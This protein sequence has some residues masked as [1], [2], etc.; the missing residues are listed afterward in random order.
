MRWRALKSKWVRRGSALFFAFSLLG[1]HFYLKGRGPENIRIDQITPRYNFAEVQVSG[2]LDSDARKMRAG[3]TLFTVNDGSGT[4]AVF[5]DEPFPEPLPK[6]GSKVTAVG[7][8]SVGVGNQVRLRCTQL[9][10]D[11]FA[12]ESEAEEGT[13][14]AVNA[15]LQGQQQTVKGTVQF[16][17]S[18]PA[19]S[20]APHKIIL[21]DDSA[22]LAVIHWLENPPDI[23]VGDVVEASGVV[24]VYRGKVELKVLK[25]GAIQKI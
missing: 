9:T 10:V 6:T 13:L 18:P 20:K 11:E 23:K 25:E 4:L 22:S 16:I 8:L 2:K 21:R 15:G 24:N 5:H 1:L 3:S 7:H 12:E 14:A 19:D 17:W